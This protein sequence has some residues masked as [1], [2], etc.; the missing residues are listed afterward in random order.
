MKRGGRL[1]VLLIVILALGGAGWWWVRGGASALGGTSAE[2]TM[3]WNGKYQGSM[4]SPAT[5]NW[6]PVTR[7]GVLEAVSGDSGLAIILY[8]RDSLTSGPHPLFSPEV[9]VGAAKPGASAVMRWVR[10]HPDT[11]VTGFRTS[12]GTVRIQFTGGKASGDIN[13][14]MR[15]VTTADS[16][17]IQGL[18]RNVPVVA[19]A[20]GCT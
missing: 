19:T 17:T 12:S 16:I 15:S 5:L 4:S 11:G 2:L 1:L 7:I 8:E 9:A 20:K 10:T 6:C 3:S 13:A 14:R 18:F